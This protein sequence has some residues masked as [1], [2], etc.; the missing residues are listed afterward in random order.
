MIDDAVWAET[1]VIGGMLLDSKYIPAVYDI[2]SGEDF[3]SLPHHHLYDTITRHFAEHGC[4]EVSALL[5][6]ERTVDIDKLIMWCAE[7]T[8]QISATVDNARLVKR[9]ANAKKAQR[10]M[11]EAADGTVTP[12]NVDTVVKDAVEQLTGLTEQRTRTKLER[13]GE[14]MLVGFYERLFEKDKDKYRV[15]TGYSRL[16]NIMGGIWKSDM[17]IVAARPGVGKSVFAVNLAARLLR[18]KKS[19]A[20]YS[21][22]MDKE[23]VLHRLVSLMSGVEMWRLRLAA[24]PDDKAPKVAE[25]VGALNDMPF[26]IN[27]EAT[28]ISAIKAECRIRGV[29]VLIVDYLSLTLP[30]GRHTSTYERVSELAR[31][32]KQLA[33]QLNIP[34]IVL[35]QLNRQTEGRVSNEP[36]MSDLRDSGE[37]EQAANQLLFL[38]EWQGDLVVKVAK[39][40]QGETGAVVMNFNKPLMQIKEISDEYR[41]TSRKGKVTLDET[42]K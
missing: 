26:Y 14:G 13:V 30:E 33:Q 21:F 27:A 28:T 38:F 39:N 3:S 7:N 37:I 4:F 15:L 24:I 34:V 1:Q 17:C 36:T 19:V 12:A 32:Y 41:P 40:R 6:E 9:Y 42:D 5:P 22:E 10:I 8:V 31:G 25:V 16:D 29:D 23:Q 2:L 35:A 20:L 18:Q 11:R